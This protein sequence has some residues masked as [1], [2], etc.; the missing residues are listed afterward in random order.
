VH[1]HT[2]VQFEGVDAEFNHRLLRQSEAA[3]GPGSFI[4]TDDAVTAERMQTAFGGAKVGRSS[5]GLGP[6][7]IDLSRGE[8][9]EQVDD[10][11]RRI[12]HVSDEVTNRAFWRQYRHAMETK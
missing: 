8:S 7:W 10:L 4:V 6:A 11:G 3:L 5:N 2:A 1:Y 9:R 12:G